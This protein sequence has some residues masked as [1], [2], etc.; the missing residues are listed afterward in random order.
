MCTLGCTFAAVAFIVHL[1][2]IDINK[3]ITSIIYPSHASRGAGRLPQRHRRFSECTP[4]RPD[5]SLPQ[6]FVRE[7]I[8]QVAD[9]HDSG[10]DCQ[11]DWKSGSMCISEFGAQAFTEGLVL[12][13][14]DACGT[15]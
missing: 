8:A 2:H 3:N 13:A 9:S 12:D 11:S 1:T 7:T 4:S 14:P 5:W 10:C 6:R 15:Y